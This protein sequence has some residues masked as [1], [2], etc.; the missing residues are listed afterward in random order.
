MSDDEAANYDEFG[1]L[2]QYAAYEGL[3]WRGRPAVRRES[4]ELSS[5]GRLSA[6]VWGTAPPELVLV[7]GSGQNAH[8]WDSVAMLLDRPL[9]ALDL[10]GHGHSDWRDD[11]DYSPGA[12]AAAV[13]ELITALAPGAG[14]VVG[15]SLGGLTTIALAA[16]QPAVV[17]RA[18]IIDITPG[19]VART[20]TERQQGTVALV[21]GPSTYESFQ[22]MLEATAAR[23]PGRSA[24]SFR[25]GV[26]HNARR[27]PDGRW[28]WRYD[29]LDRRPLGA[30][31]RQAFI[32]QLWQHVSDI[33]APLMLVR[34]GAS[35]FVSD[36]DAN[37]FV[38]RQP[39][40][41]VEVVEGA[42]HSVQSDRATHLA[43]LLEDFLAR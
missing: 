24:E 33:S 29:R 30:A 26:L 23:S 41:R 40:A 20:L 16:T 4:I 27:Q 17:A 5:G 28:G 11:G 9:V 3:E 7:H 37:E 1:F 22:A 10:P 38:R 18:A 25:P 14:L 42:G 39:S 13:G 43:G 36:E 35:A 21:R 12:N 31:D 8:T 15:M 32:D 34:G 6:L 2:E 19:I